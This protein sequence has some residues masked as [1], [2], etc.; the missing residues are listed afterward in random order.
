[1]KLSSTFLSGVL[2]MVAPSMQAQGLGQ[3]IQ[4]PDKALPSVHQVLEGT[5]LLELRRGGQGAPVPLLIQFQRDGS[6]SASAG[7]GSQGSHYGI[8]LRIGGR[9]FLLNTF[10]F[11]FGE[12]RAL[13]TI[14]KVRA[15][16]ELSEN[17]ETA[18]GTQEVVVMN[19]EGIVLATVPGGSF[20]G[21]RLRQELP[22]DFF[23][24]ANKP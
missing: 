18:T 9:R 10:L 1:M 4:A 2:L 14:T 11:G 16:F 5:W 17:G 23:E 12:N 6:I 13:T 19:R 7:D 22:A 24:F 8:W 3:T 20:T 15:N 21:V